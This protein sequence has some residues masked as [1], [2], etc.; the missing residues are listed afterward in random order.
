MRRKA[1]VNVNYAQCRDAQGNSILVPIAQEG[2]FLEIAGSTRKFGVV[3]T[4]I[5]DL[6]HSRKLPFVARMLYGSAPRLT[7]FSGILSFESIF[8]EHSM[9]A[10]S[11]AKSGLVL[12][13]LPLT[14]PC[15]FQVA[16][17]IDEL[18]GRSV[19]KHAVVLCR[20]EAE[21]YKCDLKLPLKFIYTKTLTNGNQESD[22]NHN[23]PQANG[24]RSLV[25][26]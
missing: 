8:E 2:E 14:V 4:R 7:Q 21:G 23:E 11:L 26:V 15:K 24:Y 18:L 9:I 12:T 22:E 20:K 25:Y 6:V 10:C 17:N 19:V 13:E 1:P 3:S 5:K 16:L